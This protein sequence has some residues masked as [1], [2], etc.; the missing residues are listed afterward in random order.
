MCYSFESSIRA[1]IIS[2]IL[3]TYMLANPQ[4]YNN[5]IPLMILTFTQIQIMEAIIWTSIDKNQEANKK[6]T[7]ILFFMLWLQ[8]LLNSLIGYLKML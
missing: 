5:W 6:T 7:K 2:F 8:P 4:K 3:C 1:W